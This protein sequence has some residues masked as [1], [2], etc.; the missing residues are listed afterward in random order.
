M[1]FASGTWHTRSSNVKGQE[2]TLPQQLTCELMNFIISFNAN[3]RLGDLHN[4]PCQMCNG[5]CFIQQDDLEILLLFLRP[6]T[7]LQK[8]FSILEKE[9]KIY[10]Y[11]LLK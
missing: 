7:H 1:P 5:S 10:V 2:A 11:P 3:V 4:E 9:V 6:N 8:L